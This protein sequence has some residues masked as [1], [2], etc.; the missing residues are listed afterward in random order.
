MERNSGMQTGNALG[1]VLGW[2]REED[3]VDHDVV[4]VYFLLGQLDSQTLS[5]IHGEELWDADGYEGGLLGV[6]EL[7]VDLLDFGLGGVETVKQLFLHVLRATTA[8]HLTHAAHHA[9]KLIL[10]FY[11]LEQTLLKNGWEVEE[12]KSMASR[13]SIKDNYVEFVVVQRAHHFTEGSS[14]IDAGH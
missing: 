5:L 6:F 4:N 2:I 13:R 10:Q 9:S 12:S 1:A 11:E 14:F 3:H 8:H 7:A